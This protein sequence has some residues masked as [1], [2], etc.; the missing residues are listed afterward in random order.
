MYKLRAQ[1]SKW[2]DGVVL[3]L[4]AWLFVSPWALGIASGTAVV[5]PAA[6]AWNAW[7]LAVVVGVFAVAA[8]IKEAAMG[9]MDQSGCRRLDFRFAVDLWLLPNE[10]RGAVEF[11]RRRRA[12]ICAF[13]LGSRHAT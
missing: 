7:I 3:L 4:A 5:G 6:A 9:G 12:G 8:L 11:S 10:H 2:Q 13:S 1:Q